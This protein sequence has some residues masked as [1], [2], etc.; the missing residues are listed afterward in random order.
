MSTATPKVG[1]VSL[2]CPYDDENK[3]FTQAKKSEAAPRFFQMSLIGVCNKGSLTAASQWSAEVPHGLFHPR[4]V[5]LCIRGKKRLA[6][7]LSPLHF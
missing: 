4:A 6:T 3:L 5:D 7:S 1:F 2:G